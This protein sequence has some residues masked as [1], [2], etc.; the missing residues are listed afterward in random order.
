MTLEV[1]KAL[2]DQVTRNKKAKWLNLL[3]LENWM[4]WGEL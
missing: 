1:L 2:T 3:T 4:Q